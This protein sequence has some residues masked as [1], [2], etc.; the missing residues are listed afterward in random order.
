MAATGFR[1][2]R[3]AAPAAKSLTEAVGRGTVAKYMFS[4]IRQSFDIFESILNLIKVCKEF[5][6]PNCPKMSSSLAA[7]FRP[8]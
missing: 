8:V 5:K 3:H 6:I 4:T 2:Y 7:R 1:S